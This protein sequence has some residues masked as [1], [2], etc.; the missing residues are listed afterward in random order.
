MS[1]EFDG[2]LKELAGGYL[3]PEPVVKFLYRIVVDCDP[4]IEVGKTGSGEKRVIPIIGGR[5]EGPLMSGRV[6]SVGADWNTVTPGDCLKRTVDTRYM[7]E[8]EDGAVISLFTS[9]FINWPEDVWARRQQGE[10]VDPA[11]YYF[12]QHLFFET[13]DERYKW[14]NSVVA[15][16]VV[17]SKYK[18]CPG[19]IYDAWY[20]E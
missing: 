8:T 14:L 20:L 6:L 16:G 9:G 12:K 3:P 10:H 2:E 5:F 18:G 11:S 13:A 17:I 19:V 15:F 7:L 1:S 4:P